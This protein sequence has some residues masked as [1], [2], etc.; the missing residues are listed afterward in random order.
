MWEKLSMFD[1]AMIFCHL[2]IC[3]QLNFSQH[4]CWCLC[5]QQTE[6]GDMTSTSVA[7]TIII[8]RVWSMREENSLHI[9]LKFVCNQVTFTHKKLQKSA[10][11]SNK[12]K[13]I[14][15]LLLCIVVDNC[16]ILVYSLA[17]LLALPPEEL[18]MFVESIERRGTWGW[19]R[20][21]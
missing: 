10:P 18:R 16:F 15:L 7:Q 3:F 5:F 11:S 12:L 9:F 17:F 6:S 1:V 8:T 4:H 14:Y 21:D 19:G 20:D 2:M 13:T